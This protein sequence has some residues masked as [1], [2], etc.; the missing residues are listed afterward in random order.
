MTAVLLA[1]A[2]AVPPLPPSVH[3]WPIGVGPEFELGAA[4]ARVVAG[5]PVGRFRCGRGGSRFGAHVE[6]FVHRRVLIVP[7]GIGVARPWREHLGRLTPGGCTYAARTLEPTGVVEARAGLRL[8]LRDV[9]RIWGQKLGPY[10]LAGFRGRVLAFVGG[11]RN[12][13]DPGSIPLARHAQIVLEVGGYV[14]PH[15]RYLFAPGL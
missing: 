1:L 14:P 13:G 3:P 11:V 9:F 10:R 7:A 6:L 5:R 15:P 2:F 4:P 8:T 12:R